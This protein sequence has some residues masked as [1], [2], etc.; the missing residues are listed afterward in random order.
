MS[1]TLVVANQTLPSP[2][3]AGAIATR[4]ESGVAPTGFQ[5]QIAKSKPSQNW[6]WVARIRSDSGNSAPLMNTD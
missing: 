1:T 5:D 6:L 4:I 3:L 2:A